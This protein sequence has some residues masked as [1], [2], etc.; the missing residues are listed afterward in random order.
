LFT[1]KVDEHILNLR[2]GLA[3]LPD[4]PERQELFSSSRE[5]V[6]M[7]ESIFNHQTEMA[8]LILEKRRAGEQETVNE[9]FAFN[10]K[11]QADLQE[12]RDKFQS[13]LIL[14]RFAT[15]KMLRMSYTERNSLI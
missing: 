3:N 5:L 12:S 1:I 4:D 15:A 11:A 2:T 6:G 10:A 14:S 13:I 9:L 8:N 7:I